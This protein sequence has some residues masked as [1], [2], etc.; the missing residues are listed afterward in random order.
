MPTPHVWPVIRSIRVKRS[1]SRELAREV[2]AL[3]REVALRDD[4]YCAKTLVSDPDLSKV[5]FVMKRGARM[6]HDRPRQSDAIEVLAGAVEIHLG[7]NCGDEWDMLPY[8]VRHTEGACSFFA[9]HDDTIELSVGSHV[10]L[11]PDLPFDVE[12]LTDSAFILALHPGI[13]RVS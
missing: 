9:L 5:L 11:D 2:D 7:K 3:R 1:R 13:V 4:D 6:R 8:L 12:A 10:G